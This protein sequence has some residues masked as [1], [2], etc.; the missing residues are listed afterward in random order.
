[1]TRSGGGWGHWGF[2]LVEVAVV[3]A[4]L[5]VVAA[6]TAPGLA[7]LLRGGADAV[8]HDIVTAYGEAREAAATRGAPT[9]VLLELGTGS[10]WVV[11]EPSLT[12]AVDTIR[13]ERLQLT[14]EIRLRGGSRGWVV[15]TFDPL[16]RSRGRP[17]FVDEGQEIHE[18]VA[19]PWTAAVSVRRR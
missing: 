12:T 3:L 17:V 13:H 8:V 1:M 14:P 4:I 9:R 16:G 7:R 18:I 11:V 15:T 6:V 10:Y 19:D 5:G 2:T